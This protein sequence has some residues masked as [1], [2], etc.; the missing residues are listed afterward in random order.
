[1][2]AKCL[3]VKTGAWLCK[4]GAYQHEGDE[5]CY[6]GNCNGTKLTR[7]AKATS[8]EKAV[9][10]QIAIYAQR[11]SREKAFAARREARDAGQRPR[12]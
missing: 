1:M 12:F 4:C 7:V 9:E 2:C 8:K 3:K 6:Y 11:D 10:N 5:R